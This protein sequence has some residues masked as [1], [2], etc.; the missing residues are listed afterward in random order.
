MEYTLGKIFS[1][2][3]LLWVFINFLSYYVNNYLA[4]KPRMMS[5]GLEGLSDWRNWNPWKIHTH[6]LDYMILLPWLI[7]FPIYL[8]VISLVILMLAAVVYFIVSWSRNKRKRALQL[9]EAIDKLSNQ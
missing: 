6:P 8:P 3:V 5:N 1:C 7:I 2:L 9:N 4:G